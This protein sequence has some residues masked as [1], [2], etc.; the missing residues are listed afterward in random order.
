MAHYRRVRSRTKH[1]CGRTK[2]FL[3]TEKPFMP[4]PD[5]DQWGWMTTPSSHN[6]L[7]H[8]RPRRREE[9]H[10]EHQILRG[11]DPE[12]ILWPTSKRPHKYYW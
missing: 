4:F 12:D 9:K 5:W 6:I 11:T 2:K 1:G 7:F 3:G 8:S 10:C